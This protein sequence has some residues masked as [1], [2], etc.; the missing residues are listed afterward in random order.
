MCI[1]AVLFDAG[2]GEQRPLE[3]HEVGEHCDGLS[4]R[5]VRVRPAEYPRPESRQEIT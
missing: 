1:A 3:R 2:R 4:C 5:L